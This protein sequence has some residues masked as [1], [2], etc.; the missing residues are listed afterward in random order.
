MSL[1]WSPAAARVRGPVPTGRSGTRGRRRESGQALVEFAII[2][3]IFVLLIAGIVDF[4]RVLNAWIVVSSSAREGARQ[5]SV[6]R[7]VAEVTAAA[8]SFALVP[9]VDPATVDV[10]VVYTPNRNPNP[11]RPGDSVTVT[12]TAPEFEVITPPVIAAF[13]A[14][15][16]CG[17]GAC[18]VPISSGTAMRCEGVFVE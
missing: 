1:G 10:R 5:A 12:V 4:G 14:A 8:R 3:P 17:A 9:G 15:G 6:G 11:P 7:S 16:A 18:L 2:A 13:R